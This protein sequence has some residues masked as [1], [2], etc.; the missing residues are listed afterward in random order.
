[1]TMMFVGIIVYFATK[2]LGG[3]TKR[4]YHLKDT[5]VYIINTAVETAKN[6]PKYSDPNEGN[7]NER[8]SIQDNSFDV[9]VID[10]GESVILTSCVCCRCMFPEEASTG[11]A[12]E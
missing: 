12:E 7:K 4:W 6:L 10:D 3:I 9:I 8:Y 1:M 2:L 11:V 5:T